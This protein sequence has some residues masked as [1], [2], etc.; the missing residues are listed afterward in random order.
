TDNAYL[1]KWFNELRIESLSE[2]GKI[3]FDLSND[4]FEEMTITQVD[5]PTVFTFT[6]DKD[7]VSFQLKETAESSTHLVFKEFI[8]TV[9]EHTP[10]DI[11]GWHVCLDVIRALL[12]GQTDVTNEKKQLESLY[13]KYKELFQ[14]Q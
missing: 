8:D 5:E 6:W 13:L 14:I 7:L 4:D 2:G 9:T 3:V 11:A 12:D 10:R 1:A